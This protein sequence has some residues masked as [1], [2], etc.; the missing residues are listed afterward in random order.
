MVLHKFNN[1]AIGTNF[2]IVM[3]EIYLAPYITSGFR[4]RKGGSK[5]GDGERYNNLCNTVFRDDKFS[6]YIDSWIQVGMHYAWMRPDKYYEM[7]IDQLP[8][9]N[10]DKQHLF[11]QLLYDAPPDM[12]QKMRDIFS[13]WHMSLEFNVMKECHP[14]HI[15]NHP[16]FNYYDTKR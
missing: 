9:E 14:L 12:E 2:G 13:F 1:M 10:V 3:R 5:W 6:A 16:N 11:K 7:R 15:R 8:R 4:G